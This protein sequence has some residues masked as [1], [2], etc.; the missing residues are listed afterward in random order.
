LE[1]QGKNKIDLFKQRPFN[2]TDDE[3]RSIRFSSLY[4][5][6]LLTNTITLDQRSSVIFNLKR[7]NRRKSRAFAF[8]LIQQFSAQPIDIYFHVFPSRI[9]VHIDCIYLHM[10]KF[11]LHNNSNSYIFFT[12]FNLPVFFH[13]FPLF[14]LIE[15]VLL[16]T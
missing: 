1:K 2:Y 3:L 11:I 8:V 14:S 5:F 12:K 15:A 10:H 4:K 6:C 9:Y 13:I 7:S 16:S